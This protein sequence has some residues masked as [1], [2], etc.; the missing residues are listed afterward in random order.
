MSIKS[1]LL[2]TSLLVI[3]NTSI[4]ADSSSSNMPEG[5]DIEAAQSMKAMRPSFELE[6]EKIPLSEFDPELSEPGSIKNY[7]AMVE[8]A[9]DKV[10]IPGLKGASFVSAELE[11]EIITEQLSKRLQFSPSEDSKEESW[12]QT[13]EKILEKS[14]P[15]KFDYYGYEMLD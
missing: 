7:T 9:L 3:L 1:I 15:Y 2:F 4:R 8:E 14:G 5:D 10:E 13:L 6:Q 11:N 12:V